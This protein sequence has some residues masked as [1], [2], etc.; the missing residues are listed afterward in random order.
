MS[1][2]LS[3]VR[4]VLAVSG[5]MA[6][7][8]AFGAGVP[9]QPCYL[10]LT[11]HRTGLVLASILMPDVPVR[12]SVEF[13]HSVL[14]TRVSDLYEMRFADGLW[15]AHLI[16]ERFEGEGYGLP[17]GATEQGQR[18]ERDAQGWRLTLDRVVDPL[19]QLPLPE[20]QVDLVWSGGRIRIASVSQSSVRITLEGCQTR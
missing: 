8:C 12:F 5:L 14:G 7:T 19:V 15:Q 11:Q 6:W 17:Y 20:Q 3:K 18:Y 1:N 16:E 2:K 10:T 9:A 13:I 4:A